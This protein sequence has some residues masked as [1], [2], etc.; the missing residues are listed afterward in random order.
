LLQQLLTERSDWQS[1]SL[2]FL[3]NTGGPM[4]A[5]GFVHPSETDSEQ[6]ST[7]STVSGRRYIRLGPIQIDVQR[8]EVTKYGSRLR[9]S[10]KPYRVLLALLERPGEVVSREAICAC[11]WPPDALVD[12]ESNISMTIN[13]LRRALGD[14]ATSPR[15]IKTIP[16]RGYALVGCPEISEYPA[17][18]ADPGMGPPIGVPGTFAVGSSRWFVL[19]VPVF[20]LA[21]ALVGFGLT[22]AWFSYFR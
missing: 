22:T 14:S 21:G 13:K 6:T 8:E 2:Q 20:V 12:Y 1:L 3:G 11:L 7:F 19:C 16:R 5:I 15:Y 18:A 4:T 17:Q 9:L 10:G